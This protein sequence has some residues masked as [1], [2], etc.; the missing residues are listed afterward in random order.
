MDVL[1]IGGTG[2]ISTAVVEQA[3]AE[4][5]RVSILNRGSRLL[6][7]TWQGQVECLVA[8]YRDDAA[9]TQVLGQRHWDVVVQFISYT[10][11]DAARDV[12]FFRQRTEQF[13]FIS[14]ASAYQKPLQNP[15][16]TEETPLSNPYWPYSAHKAE[17]ERCYLQAW[18]EEGFPVVLIRPSHTYGPRQI[19]VPIHGEKGS[20][21]VLRRIQEHKPI[22]VHG[23]G[24]SLWTITW[25]ADLAVGLV[26]L[27]GQKAACGEAF[28][29]TSDERLPWRR[30]LE[31]SAEAVGEELILCP[32]SS[33]MLV[34]LRPDLQGPLLGDK[35]ASVCFDN[36]KIKKWVPAF[37]P[38][39]MAA[40]GIRRAW[41]Y[42]QAHP[43]LQV[44]DPAFDAFCDAVVERVA[45][46]GQG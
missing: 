24:E 18:E 26:G 39:V 22:L 7:A 10:A 12:A 31:L 3:L 40:E 44:T 38:K 29:I 42:I 41:T 19:P 46:F 4:Q 34:Q 28:H 11:E 30:L 45:A 43:E 15:V 5:H 9:L 8:D 27:W 32:V 21:A 17:A 25:A 2:T 33:A 20:F 35:A 14:S 6:P 23:D 37:A 16:I 13:F 36:S 1:I